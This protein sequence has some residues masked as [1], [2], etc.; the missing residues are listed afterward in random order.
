[1]LSTQ[2][3]EVLKNLQLLF[4]DG[5]SG[6]LTDGELLDRFTCRR[7]ESAF[8]ILV[9]RHG[10]MV[11]R[12][13]RAILADEHDAHDAFQ[14]TFL[15]LVR[16]AHSIDRFVSVGPWLF[17]VCHRIAVRARADAV[18]RR[19]RERRSA[20][21]RA[22]ERER[23]EPGPESWPELYAELARLPEKYRAPVVLC[24]LEGQTTEEAAR[25]LGCP[26][27]T[28]L[29]RLARARGRLRGRLARH[30]LAL[31]AIVDQLITAAARNGHR[32]GVPA[33]LVEATGPRC[34]SAG[35]RRYRGRDNPGSSHHIDERNDWSHEAHSTE[36]R[37]RDSPRRWHGHRRSRPCPANLHVPAERQVR[38]QLPLLDNDRIEL[39]RGSQGRSIFRITRGSCH[40]SRPWP[41]RRRG[42]E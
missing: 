28:V 12:V 4:Q 15:V 8:S 22:S 36:N 41:L 27:G 24:Y 5:T 33:S 38:G 17:G 39:F 6:D 31:P 3:G 25:R 35:D 29:S 30:G 32:R 9:E 23:E 1:M 18:R 42:Q 14:A 13:C 40:R 34:G 11:L 10:V 19:M 26:R 2:S 37:R 21:M 20:E 16:R 7:D